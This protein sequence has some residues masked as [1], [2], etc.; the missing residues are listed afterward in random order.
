[1]ANVKKYS[2]PILVQLRIEADTVGK[3]D[4]IALS[5]GKSRTDIVN[6]AINAYLKG[7]KK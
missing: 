5:S 3:L 4:K 7:G 2:Q 1:M 6:Q